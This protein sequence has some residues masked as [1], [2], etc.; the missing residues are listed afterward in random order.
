MI[1]G[2]S[3]GRVHAVALSIIICLAIIAPNQAIAE[4]VLFCPSSTSCAAG[5]PCNLSNL[6]VEEVRFNP[7]E[8]TQN[9]YVTIFAKIRNGGN[10]S[11]Q[12][13]DVAAYMDGQPLAFTDGYG[14]LDAGESVM[15][16][17]PAKKF[18]PGQHQIEIYADYLKKVQES[19]ECDN[20]M[21]KNVTV[22]ACGILPAETT[23]TSTTT[24]T[25][26]PLPCDESLVTLFSDE[27]T[28]AN[29]AP[30]AEAN[31]TGSIWT[32]K[33]PGA[34]WIW[35]SQGVENPKENKSAVFTR[36]F[37]IPGKPVS[38]RITVAADNSYAVYMN[39]TQVYSDQSPYN[40]N[41]TQTHYVTGR[42]TSGTNILG[43]TVLD[44]RGKRDNPNQA[45]L[46]YKLEV[47]YTPTAPTTTT[48]AIAPKDPDKA[49]IPSYEEIPAKAYASTGENAEKADTKMNATNIDTAPLVIG[50]AVSF[51]PD[52]SNWLGLLLLVLLAVIAA[53]AGFI[54]GSKNSN[55]EEPP[56]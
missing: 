40:Y 17:V 13:W 12:V 16:S 46:L 8:P 54:M 45:G 4:N 11:P 43:F 35:K 52:G 2:Q 24:T 3:R 56:A 26:P 50:R 21:Q 29:F 48:I 9:D 37:D 33:I 28:L 47:C 22:G 44:I 6:R 53:Y 55:K 10:A 1:C 32:A 25:I 41:R 51:I 34:K 30:S 19:N 18:T 36:T 20:Y 31:D 7:A 38:G 5:A 23:T 15:I 39:W 27:N 49:R 14:S 42:I